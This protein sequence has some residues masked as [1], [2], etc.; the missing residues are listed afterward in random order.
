MGFRFRGLGFRVQGF[1]VEFRVN[2]QLLNQCFWDKL[3]AFQSKNQ[4]CGARA[5]HG[6]TGDI[7]SDR[8]CCRRPGWVV[9][10]V[11]RELERSRGRGHQALQ[12]LRD[13]RQEFIP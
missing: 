8:G 9:R 12:E 7:D 13:S 4:L 1:R 10:L 2:A 3:L 11:A 6:L 5:C